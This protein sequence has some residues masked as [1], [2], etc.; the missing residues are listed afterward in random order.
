VAAIARAAGFEPIDAGPL[1]NAAVLENL[2][3]LW[4]HLAMVGG[5]GRQVGFKLLGR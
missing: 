4:I 2:A 3:M 1:R 5:H